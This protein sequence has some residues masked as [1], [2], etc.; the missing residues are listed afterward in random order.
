M[1]SKELFL[2]QMYMKDIQPNGTKSLPILGEIEQSRLR[3]FIFKTI[4]PSSFSLKYVQLTQ[5]YLLKYY[6]ESHLITNDTIIDKQ[7]SIN[8]MVPNV[9]II[10]LNHL[11][12]VAILKEIYVIRYKWLRGGIT[13]MSSECFKLFLTL[14]FI[15]V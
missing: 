7:S 10:G 2:F 1:M 13:F 9:N 11:H 15:H 3:I 14:I 5:I 8:I 4:F 12:C 6:F